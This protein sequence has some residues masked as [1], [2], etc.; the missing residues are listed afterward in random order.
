MVWFV[1]KM[2]ER[3]SGREDNDYKVLGACERLN[4]EQNVMSPAPRAHLRAV[5]TPDILL[6]LLRVRQF[7]LFHNSSTLYYNCSLKKKEVE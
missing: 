6:L 5:P 4:P 1:N 7:L 3:Q 2:I